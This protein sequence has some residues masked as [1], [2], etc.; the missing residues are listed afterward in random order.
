[1]GGSSGCGAGWI[2]GDVMECTAVAAAGSD[3]GD[4]ASSS[5]SV[6]GDGRGGDGDSDS[7]VTDGRGNDGDGDSIVDSAVASYG[8]GDADADDASGSEEVGGGST[9][10]SIAAASAPE[11]DMGSTTSLLSFSAKIAD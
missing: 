11:F 3:A 7:I 10:M 9:C 5:V 8:S 6:V 2:A 4:G 1:M